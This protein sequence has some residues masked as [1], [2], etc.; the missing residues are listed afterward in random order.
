MYGEIYNHYSSLIFKARI[1]IITVIFLAFGYIFGIVPH[2]EKDSQIPEIVTSLI[3]PVCSSAF[4]SLIF[5]T[6]VAYF[7]ILFK[8]I[9][10]LKCLEDNPKNDKEK[11]YSFFCM[12]KRTHWHFTSLYLVA[13]IAFT[14]IYFFN[15]IEDW[16]KLPSDLIKI[17]AIAFGCVPFPFM[18]W[19]WTRL[20]LYYH[21]I[22]KEEKLNTQ[23]LFLV[24][25]GMSKGDEHYYA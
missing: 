5:L 16:D 18:F 12:Y 1:S 17:I 24:S 6:E 11:P 3:I 8:A 21:E 25:M 2:Q 22:I 19:V 23:K 20:N 14:C 15:L 7:K 10:A 4:V 9:H 13:S